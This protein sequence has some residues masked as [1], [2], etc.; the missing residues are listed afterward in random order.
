MGYAALIVAGHAPTIAARLPAL[1]ELAQPSRLPLWIAAIAGVKVLH[2]LGHALACRHFGARPAEMGVLLLAGAPTLYCDVSDAWRLPS[3][4]RR[5]AVSSAGMF[6]ELFIA[7]VAA[8]VWW[9]A[10]PGLLAALCLSLIIVCSVGTVAVNLNPL[11]RYDGYYLLADWLET[12]NLAER[13]RGLVSGAWRQWLLGQP[14][15]C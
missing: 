15:A 11:L 10:A 2:E 4:W 9:H 1:S 3:K 6:V 14:S 13:A 5:M 12:P 8:I 7:A